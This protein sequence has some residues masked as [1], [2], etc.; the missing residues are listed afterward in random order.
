MCGFKVL[1]FGLNT[2]TGFE[3]TERII[4]SSMI[5]CY[6]RVNNRLIY[7][8]EVQQGRDQLRSLDLKMG[9]LKFKKRE[10]LNI[11]GSKLGKDG[12]DLLV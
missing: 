5:A 6:L 11:R 4:S 10:T 2:L 7:V 8:Q 3:V 1:Q 12:G 9:M